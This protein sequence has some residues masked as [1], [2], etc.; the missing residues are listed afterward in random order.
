MVLEKAAFLKQA[1]PGEPAQNAEARPTPDLLHLCLVNKYPWWLWG[2]LMRNQF[3]LSYTFSPP[4]HHL[5][6]LGPSGCPDLGV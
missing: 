5:E 1:S 3:F 2:T 6:V 4:A